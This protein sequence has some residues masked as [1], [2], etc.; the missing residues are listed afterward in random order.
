MFLHQIPVGHARDVIAHCPV[1]AFALDPPRRAFAQQFRRADVGLE[2][3]A[4]HLAGLLVHLCHPR[5]IIDVLIEKAPQFPV[6][7]TPFP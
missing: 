1:Q 4:Q 2:N 3:R 5:M 7:L 6:R